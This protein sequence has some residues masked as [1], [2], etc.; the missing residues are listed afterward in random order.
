MKYL[1]ALLNCYICCIW[2][3]NNVM[4]LSAWVYPNICVDEG[5][6]N[7]LSTNLFEFYIQN[8]FHQNV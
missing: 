3:L 1:A 7:V 2:A 4:L 5:N 6:L 8:S